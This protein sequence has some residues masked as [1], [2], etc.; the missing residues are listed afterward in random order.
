MLGH[1]STFQIEL[2]LSGDRRTKLSQDL[3]HYVLSRQVADEDAW[4]K[5][6][7]A[8]L[9]LGN[10]QLTVVKNW[11]VP[12]GGAIGPALAAGNLDSDDHKELLVG[13]NGGDIFVVEFSTE[14][15]PT[16][17]ASAHSGRLAYGI[18]AGDLN[19][20]G[21]DEFVLTRGALG[22]AGMTEFD[23]VAEVWT[24]TANKLRRLWVQRTIDCPRPLLREGTG[25]LIV[26][27]LTDKQT[28]SRVLTPQWSE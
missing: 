12:S 5:P 21:R 9:E 19:N 28:F 4:L 18:A 22:Y 20:D 27:S 17:A 7:F 13:T 24:F 2:K 14:G 23:V 26:Y 11:Q 10:D 16:F 6:L 8:L 15:A 3:R 1:P 25:E